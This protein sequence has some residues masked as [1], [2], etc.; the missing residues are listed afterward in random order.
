MI[1]TG[2]TWYYDSG[3][4]C[5][6][7]NESPLY[8]CLGGRL[9]E[10]NVGPEQDC[11]SYRNLELTNEHWTGIII[12]ENENNVMAYRSGK[13][14]ALKNQW[15]KGH[16]IWFPSMIDIGSRITSD[17]TAIAEFYR[18]VCSK[19]IAEAG[20]SFDKAY[21]DVFCRALK[22]GD[23]MMM[24]LVNKSSESKIIKINGIPKN[25]VIV[26]GNGTFS[27]GGI[28]LPAD[29]YIVLAF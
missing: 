11:V 2:M 25:P 4:R 16:S 8:Q 5:R 1:S 3:M 9:K 23:E 12:P 21:Q 20:F 26:D 7:A 18:E 24:L 22:N 28:K 15:G 19:T 17:D 29:G 13:P 10:F 27:R 6:F 14:I